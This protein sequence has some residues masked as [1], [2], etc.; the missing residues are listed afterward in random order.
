MLSV[1]APSI[2]FYGSFGLRRC[3]AA[4]AFFLTVA[5]AS[6]KV[7]AA[8][9][10]RTPKKREPL[11]GVAKFPPDARQQSDQRRPTNK[12]CQALPWGLPCSDLHWRPSIR[13]H[14]PTALRPAL[15]LLLRRD[16][17]SSSAPS[18]SAE[19]WFPP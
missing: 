19:T 13:S 1:A 8:K 15:R 7:T 11:P 16:R 14:S 6:Q 3:F 17:L 10:R 5:P 18:W 4:L 12:R 2:L 9:D